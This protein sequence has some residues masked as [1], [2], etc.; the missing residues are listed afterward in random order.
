VTA[1][2]DGDSAFLADDQS[3]SVQIDY[4]K[5]VEGLAAFTEFHSNRA[6]S[7]KVSARSRGVIDQ[8]ISVFTDSIRGCPGEIS[9]IPVADS[10][11]SGNTFLP[12]IPI[13]Q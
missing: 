5:I 12:Q 2:V 6:H 13:G 3:P 10:T 11:F 7:Q 4:Q 9:A 8:A 1:N